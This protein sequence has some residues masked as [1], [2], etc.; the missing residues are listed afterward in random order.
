MR[1]NG[2]KKPN[3]GIRPVAVG[4]TFR[5]VSANRARYHVFESRQAR[6]RSQQVGVGTKRGTEL[7]S[8]VMRCLIDSPQPKK[9]ISKIDFEN[10]SSSMNPLF[11]LEKTSEIHPAVYKYSHS[12]CS[13]PSFL[14]KMIK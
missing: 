9:V 11:M 5:Q 13:Q 4:N 10:V 12:A 7:A 1:I 6:Y 3:R 2:A 8:P 14:F